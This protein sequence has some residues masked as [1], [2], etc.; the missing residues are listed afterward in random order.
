MA[1]LLAHYELY[2]KITHLPGAVIE[3]GV[4]KGASFMR[5]AGFRDVL[6]NS[7]SRPLIGFDAFGS[8]PRDGVAGASD[9]QFIDHFETA[10]GQGIARGDLERLIAA[11]GFENTE[12]VEG[13]IFTTVPEY[14]AKHPA[15]KIALLHLD[16]DVYEPTAFALDQLLPSMVRGGLVLF[17]DYGLVAGATR[18]ADAA[19]DRLGVT[20]AKL[21]HYQIPAYFTAP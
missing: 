2:R 18:A 4:Y 16:L 9:Q 6:E 10:G 12:L 3:L 13:N 5:F 14:L 7:Y 21:S 1:K 15:L 19:C 11:K 8:F 20:M 17:D